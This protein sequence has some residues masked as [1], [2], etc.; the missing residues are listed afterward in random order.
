[1]TVLDLR[2]PQHQ[3][4]KERIQPYLDFATSKA[5]R[6]AYRLDLR[7]FTEWGA[8]LP[9]T[10]Q[11]VAGYLACYAEILSPA[12]LQR[13]LSAISRAHDTLNV[14][15]PVKTEGIRLLMRG[16]RR[17]RGTK[18]REAKPL[19]R[20]DLVHILCCMG[21]D[22][23]DV[24]D[25]ALLM[26]GFAGAFRRS[27]LV[28][29][30]V[31][32]LQF[33]TQGV[34][35]TIRHSKTDQEGKGRKVGIPNGRHKGLCPVQALAHWLEAS[36]ITTGPVFRPVTRSSAIACTR[37]TDRSVANIIK[38]RASAA[39]MEAKDLSGHSLRR[40]C[41]SSAAM[42]GIPNHKLKAQSGH[43][44]DAMLARYISDAD[45]WNNN[46]GGLF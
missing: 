40:G 4:L 27:E 43:K 45:I 19:L 14:P 17:K 10:V 41:L 30:D 11:M 39:G 20:D 44:S 25:R 38:S 1:M 23:R 46:A 24:R 33:V 32:D 15:N 16:I 7:H 37:L 34:L 13:R 42:A 35:V 31:E 2:N 9:A 26:C 18:Q 5:T 21:S 22:P 3:L 6:Q 8:T 29:L 12:T 28:S 36:G